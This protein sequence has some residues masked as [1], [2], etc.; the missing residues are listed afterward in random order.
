MSTIKQPQNSQGFTIVELLVVIVVIAI[1]ASVS[2]VAY[3]GI[4]DRANASKAA[5]AV[6]QYAKVF[7]IYKVEE[8]EFPH[9]DSVN[10][11]CLGPPNS[12]PSTG[13]FDEGSCASWGEGQGFQQHYANEEIN[14]A[15]QSVITQIPSATLSTVVATSNRD[16]WSSPSPSYRGIIYHN[17]GYPTKTAH[18]HYFLKGTQ[19]C[20]QGDAHAYGGITE[21]VVSLDGSPTDDWGYNGGEAG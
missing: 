6:E 2:V 15:L 8:G 16:G 9:S 10:A 20:P 13:V 19:A 14:D 17:Y 21:C 5:S 1:L 3:N 18:I 11:V 7:Q 4:Q 12:F